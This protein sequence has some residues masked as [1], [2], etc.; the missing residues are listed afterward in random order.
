MAAYWGIAAHSAYYM[1]SLYKNL[2]KVQ[3]GKDQEKAQSEKDSH[4]KNQDGEK[5][6][7]TIRYLYHENI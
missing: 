7:P 4:S 3:V 2:K 1:F 6:K 5:N